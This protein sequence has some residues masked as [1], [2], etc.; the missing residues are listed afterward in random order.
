MGSGTFAMLSHWLQAAGG[1]VASA[2]VPWW[3]SVWH[4]GYPS[5]LLLQQVLLEESEWHTAVATIGSH[6]VPF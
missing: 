3:A 4:T 1:S 2:R 6:L 5:S